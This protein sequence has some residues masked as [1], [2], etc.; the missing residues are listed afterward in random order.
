[1]STS[2]ALVDQ[3]DAL[4]H[5]F[6]QVWELCRAIESI[7]SLVREVVPNW[8]AIQDAF[9][10]YGKVRQWLWEHSD[11][12]R[13]FDGL[14]NG[15]PVEWLGQRFQS[16]HDAFVRVFVIDQ[17]SDIQM[18]L[19]LGT[20]DGEPCFRVP[21]V[22]DWLKDDLGFTG[23]GSVSLRDRIWQRVRRIAG[24]PGDAAVLLDLPPDV[25]VRQLGGWCSLL[26]LDMWI[27][28]E[29]LK[30]EYATAKLLTAPPTIVIPPVTSVTVRTGAWA[31]V[32]GCSHN[33]ARK[34]LTEMEKA[35]NAR[36]TKGG[37]W[38]VSLA[39]LEPEERMTARKIFSK[40]QDEAKTKREKQLKVAME[41]R[42]KRRARSPKQPT[43][44]Q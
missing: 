14:H 7:A 44:P 38:C 12:A 1:M 20:E 11:A 6:S 9:V 5:C 3:S 19:W 35:G 17:S 32:F 13:Q 24:M 27:W 10:R 8:A 37:V 25:L 39:S 15:D 33:T 28:P 40:L 29:Q 4:D 21:D 30:A 41:K 42:D 16:W 36:E 34:K 26:C 43:R 2:A 31:E 23:P 22:L 18:A